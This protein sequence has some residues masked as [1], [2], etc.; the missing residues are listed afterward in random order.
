M[1]LLPLLPVLASRAAALPPPLPA[2][3]ALVTGTPDPLAL[4]SRP[5]GA[6]GA[7]S[8]GA[9]A[10]AA[11]A[12]AASA[13]AA[14]ARFS[15]NARVLVSS[16]SRRDAVRFSA[17]FCAVRLATASLSCASWE[18]DGPPRPPAAREAS[19]SIATCLSLPANSASRLTTRL[20]RPPSSVRAADAAAR[21][22][23]TSSAEGPAGGTTERAA[24]AAATALR[25]P[26]SSACGVGGGRHICL[27]ERWR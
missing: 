8:F 14:A 13:A 2:L 7:C 11:A 25:A 15:R 1:G 26:F 6:A 19:S 16:A 10:A 23:S 5:A 17:V 18:A 4:G 9:A 20:R 21:A 12:A 24:S 3:C 22:S 27:C